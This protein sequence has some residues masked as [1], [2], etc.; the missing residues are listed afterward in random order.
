METSARASGEPVPEPGQELGQDL[1]AY[2]AGLDGDLVQEGRTL[3]R[4]LAGPLAR[5]TRR[6]GPAAEP[7]GQAREPGDRASGLATRASGLGARTAGRSARAATRGAQAVGRGARWTA[8]RL[9]SEVLARV[10]RLPVRD[11]ATLRAQFPGLSP[12]ELADTLIRSAARMSASV[13]AAVGTWAVLPFLPGFPAELATETITVVGIEI[14]LI[15][16]LH[17]VFGMRAPGSV[18]ERMTAYTGAWANRRGVGLAPAGLVLAMG[19]PL[20]RRLHRRLAARA[21]TSAASLGPLLTGA[22]AGALINRYETRR[23]GGEIRDDLRQRS[24]IAAQWYH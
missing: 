22:V 5:V 9:V 15:A 11:Q 4:R 16:E 2:T 17:E 10:P 1:G 14:K 24:P 23:L 8:A 7:D 3:R 6:G 21:G 12:E 20:R 18:V 19:S 13:G